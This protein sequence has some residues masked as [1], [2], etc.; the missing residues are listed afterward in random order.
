MSHGY[1]MSATNPLGVRKPG[2]LPRHWR[3]VGRTPTPKEVLK[4]HFGIDLGNYERNIDSLEHHAKFLR[5]DNPVRE[6]ELQKAEGIREEVA[7]HIRMAN[8]Y[9]RG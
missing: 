6:E 1:S 7:Q 4:V 2:F 9:L 5:K 8:E 3:K